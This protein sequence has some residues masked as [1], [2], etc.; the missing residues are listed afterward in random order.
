MCPVA[1]FANVHA[2]HSY[3]VQ[4]PH[5]SSDATVIHKLNGEGGLGWGGG[6]SSAKKKSARNVCKLKCHGKMCQRSATKI[7]RDTHA[8]TAH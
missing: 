7:E 3:S 4:F 5:F 2:I 1:L 8:C 6:G